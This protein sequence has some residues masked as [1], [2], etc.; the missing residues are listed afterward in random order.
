MNLSLKTDNIKPKIGITLNLPKELVDLFSNGL[1]QNTIF[2][3]KLLKNIGKYDVYFIFRNEHVIDNHL[4][5]EMKFDYVLEENILDANFN[6]NTLTTEL[7][8][9]KIDAV[10]DNLNRV[11]NL[12]MADDCLWSMM[13]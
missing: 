11:L 6:I 12:K 5:N 4:L 3:Y 9:S 13:T 2:F 1:R 10:H 8:A 7:Y